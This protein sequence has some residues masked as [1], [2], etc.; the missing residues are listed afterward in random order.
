MI[1]QGV[2]END[3]LVRRTDCG[4]GGHNLAEF[5]LVQDGR[6]SGRIQSHHQDSHFFLSPQSIEQLRECKTHICDVVFG[7]RNVTSSA[8]I[9]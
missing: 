4:N 8:A 3:H 1:G 9:S 5:Q 6:L 2:L 7:R